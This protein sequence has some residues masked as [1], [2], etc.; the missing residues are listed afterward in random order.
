MKRS[1]SSFSLSGF[2]RREI[3]VLRVV[4]GDVVELP[5]VAIEHIG[6]FDRA[7]EP[8]G[9]RRRRGGD[10][11]IVVNRAVAEHLEVLRVALRRRFRVR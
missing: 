3:V 7:H 8:R 10:P 6:H 1:C 11:A 9:L 5:F 2:L 4:F